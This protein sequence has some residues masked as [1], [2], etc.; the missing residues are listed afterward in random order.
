M[1]IKI[2]L[3]FLALINTG[4]LLSQPFQNIMISNIQAPEEPS[5][6]INPKNLNQ[7][8][9]GANLNSY[10]YS[11]NGGLNWTRGVLVDNQNGVY[12]DPCIIA[13]TSGNFYYFHLADPPGS[14][15]SIE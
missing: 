10:Y 4:I 5:I 8:V 3:L 12:G 6:C 7:V 2:T 15:W 9:A 11:S 1:R 14:P 13:D